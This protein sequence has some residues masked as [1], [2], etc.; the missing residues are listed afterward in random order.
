MIKNEYDQYLLKVIEEKMEDVDSDT[1]RDMK[2]D[3]F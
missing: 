3:E 1:F 2:K